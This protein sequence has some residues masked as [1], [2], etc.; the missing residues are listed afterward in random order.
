MRL[1]AVPPIVLEYVQL[2]G[3][4]KGVRVLSCVGIS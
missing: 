4:G 1:Q 3:S 2:A